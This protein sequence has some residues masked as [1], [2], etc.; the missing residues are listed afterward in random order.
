MAR[1]TRIRRDLPVD[2]DIDAIWKIASHIGAT[3]KQFRAAYSR[4]LQRTAATLRKR[5]MAGM[6]EG[7]APRSLTMARKRLLSF[8]VG[9]GSELDEFRLWFGLN[10]IKVKDLK[11]KVIGRVLPHHNRRDKKTGRYIASRRKRKAAGFAPNGALLKTQ[12]WPDGEVARTRKE[13]RRTVVIR[14]P[15]THRTREAEVDIYEPMLNFIED[16]AFAEAMEIF[17]HHFNS[18]IRGR[19]KSKVSL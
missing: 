5:T 12:T 7:I 17:M 10:A 11:G 1:A 19:V 16:N 8:R 14:D 9:R 2:I 6:K 15:K 4:A 3:Q 13:G 18:D